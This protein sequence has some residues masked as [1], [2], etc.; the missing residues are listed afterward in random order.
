MPK[1]YTVKW[2]ATQLNCDRRNVY[3]IFLRQ[4]IDTELLWRISVILNHDFFK[5][6]SNSLQSSKDNDN[7]SS[8]F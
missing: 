5:D 3:D 1:K 8:K 6:I 2:F 7:L 4:S